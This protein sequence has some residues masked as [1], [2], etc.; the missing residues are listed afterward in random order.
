[1]KDGRELQSWNA[2]APRD[3]SLVKL[4]LTRL[5]QPAKAECPMCSMLLA[6]IDMSLV[7]FWN[8]ASPIVETPVRVTS[9]RDDFAK[10]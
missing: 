5:R 3:V 10:Q 7:H 9:M 8:A 4:A 6:D 2:S 1:M